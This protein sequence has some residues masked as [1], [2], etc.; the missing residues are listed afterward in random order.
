ME[1]ICIDC[2]VTTPLCVD[3][4]DFDFIGIAKV[5][6]T[7]KNSTNPEDAVIAKRD[8]TSAA[9][10]CVQITPQ[11]SLRLKDGAVYDITF[12]TSGSAPVVC[13]NGENGVIEL[14]RGV[15]QQ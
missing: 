10:H 2:G 7:L 15:G 5:T 14:R 13:K 11:E 12:T 4:S 9:V 6:L 8:F 3:L 1:K